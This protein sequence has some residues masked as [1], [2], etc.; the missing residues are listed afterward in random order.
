MN[1]EYYKEKC[2][3]FLLHKDKFKWFID[4]YFPELYDHLVEAAEK[5]M[6][7]LLMKELSDVWFYLPDSKFNIIE[8]PPGWTE[9]LRILDD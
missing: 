7:S 2:E 1:E 9:F 4:E 5:R 8:N 3:Q 6:G